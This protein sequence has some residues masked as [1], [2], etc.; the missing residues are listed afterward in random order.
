MSSKITKL[1][2]TNKKI[3]ARGGISLFLCYIQNVKLYGLISISLGS[4]IFLSS[5]GLQ[6]EQ[7]LKQMFAFF[8]DGTD[9]SI[10]SFD[11]KKKDEG[12]RKSVV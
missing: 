7:F 1:G 12:D 11:R 6:L 3:S 8:I 10:S 9:M 4:F 2:I 5:R